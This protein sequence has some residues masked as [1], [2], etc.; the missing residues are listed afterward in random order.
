MNERTIGRRRFDFDRQVAVMAVVNRTPD[1]FYDRGATFALDRAVDAALAAAERGADWVD[2]GGV[3]FGQGPHVSVAEEIDRIVP[4]V[5]AITQASDVV[6]SVDT[7]RA[8]VAQA[9]IKAGAAVINDT[10][11]LGDPDMADVISR[12]DAHL[13]ITHSVGPPRVEKP[14]AYFADVVQDV[15]S[16][17]EERVERAEAAG[18]PRSRIIID[19]GHDLDKNTRHSL[20]LTRHLDELSVL[21]LPILAAVSN[22]DFIGESIDREQGHRLA[23]SIAAMAVC[24]E[25]GARIVRMHDVEAA[26]DAVRMVEAILGMRQPARLDHNTHPTR[27]V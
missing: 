26:V 19:P 18:I 2:I 22:K 10:S 24:I 6:V 1:S 9:A 11:G 20:E 17:L 7:N 14:A 23:G 8:L 21:G 4:V 3:P 25:R 27:N 12:S 13:V 15:R 16:F 5:E